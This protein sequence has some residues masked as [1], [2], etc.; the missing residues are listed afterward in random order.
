MEHLES[1]RNAKVRTLPAVLLGAPVALTPTLWVAQ[2]KPKTVRNGECNSQCKANR[3]LHTPSDSEKMGVR[4][5]QE[6]HGIPSYINCICINLL[7]CSFFVSNQVL[8][9]RCPRASANIVSDCT[10]YRPS[11]CPNWLK[12]TWCGIEFRSARSLTI[13]DSFSLV[14]QNSMPT[15]QHPGFGVETSLIVERR[16]TEMRCRQFGQTKWNAQNCLS[17]VQVRCVFGY[18]LGEPQYFAAYIGS[19]Q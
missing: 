15:S 18:G 3:A 14:Y 12:P 8:S 10:V 11:L 17:F 1:H 19:S 13:W 16:R 4:E 2:L 7:S 5:L 6:Y 9:C